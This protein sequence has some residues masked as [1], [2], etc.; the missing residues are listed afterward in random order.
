[1]IVGKQDRSTAPNDK[2]PAANA[3]TLAMVLQLHLH[4]LRN[5]LDITVR[6]TS[7]PRQV[8]HVFQLDCCVAVLDDTVTMD[9][10]NIIHDT[11]EL[12]ISFD[13]H[14]LKRGMTTLTT[15]VRPNCNN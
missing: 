8:K 7:W 3:A 5:A 4:S 11:I 2:Q 10:K 6:A 13:P 15:K 12:F 14:P 1:L 9:V